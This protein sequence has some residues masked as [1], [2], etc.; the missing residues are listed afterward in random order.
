MRYR[1]T[2]QLRHPGFSYLELQV[3]LALFA[4]ALAGLGPLIIL[5]SRQGRRLEERLATGTTQYFVPS[6]DPWVRKLGA[7]A[8]LAAADPPAPPPPVTLV[9]NADPQYRETDPAS[10]WRDQP[11]GNAVGGRLRFHGRGD[12]SAKARWQF[13]RITPGW[14]EVF[15]AFDADSPRAKATEAPVSI[16]DGEVAVATVL[17]D[18]TQPPAGNVFA[19]VAWKSLGVFP[20]AGDSLRVEL[21]DDADD[22]VVADAARIVRR[23]NDVQLMTVDKS[24]TEDTCTVEATVTVQV[25]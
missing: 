19:G 13:T 25:P 24:F 1:F 12:G 17:V 9:D 10:G 8:A 14:H 23:E 20:I 16:Y 11:A 5:Q 3:A 6:R 21:S 2:P 15:L 7:A 18:Q 4:F 22:T